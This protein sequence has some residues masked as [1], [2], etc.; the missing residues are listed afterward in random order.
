MSL[1]EHRVASRAELRGFAQTLV[2]KLA[3]GRV[4]ALEGP[5]GAGKTT[6]VR[7]LIELLGLAQFGLV[8]PGRPQH[9]LYLTPEPH[10]QGALRGGGQGS[11]AVAPIRSM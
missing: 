3:P 10:Q 2:A 4:V 5:M 9:F 7:E 11:S 8:R 6:L 1:E